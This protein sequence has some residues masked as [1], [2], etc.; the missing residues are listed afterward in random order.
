MKNIFRNCER[1]GKNEEDAE[2]D[3]GKQRKGAFL[4]VIREF[5]G[6]KEAVLIRRGYFE[7]L[8]RV[9]G[10]RGQAKIL[11]LSLLI[12]IYLTPNLTYLPGGP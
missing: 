2:G 5:K 6:R 9:L 7:F 10:K 11:S 4:P 3:P 8:L 12:I 1:Q